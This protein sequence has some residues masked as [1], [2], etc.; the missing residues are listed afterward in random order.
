[1]G[2]KEIAV[3]SVTLPLTAGV[4]AVTQ[5][6]DTTPS[7]ST[8]PVLQK[9]GCAAPLVEELLDTGL[10]THGHSPT[11]V[12]ENDCYVDELPSN[13]VKHRPFPT[14]TSKPT[15]ILKVL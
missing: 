5:T 9:S 2:L 3:M 14:P 7:S 11:R 15:V 4:I 8:I 6:S 10:S 1:M 13:I 12:C